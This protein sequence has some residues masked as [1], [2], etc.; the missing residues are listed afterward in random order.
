M[1]AT[2][3]HLSLSISLAAMVRRTRPGRPK[4]QVD[5]ATDRKQE[6]HDLHAVPSQKQKEKAPVRH[7][8]STS[9]HLQWAPVVRRKATNVPV[10]FSHDG[11]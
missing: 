6:T 9:P 2:A 1:E 10:V 11:E 5:S 3:R 7:E 8:L 4:G